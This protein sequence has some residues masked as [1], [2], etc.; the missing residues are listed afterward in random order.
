ML[1]YILSRKPY[2]SPEISNVFQEISGNSD[3]ASLF[4]IGSAVEFAY[5]KDVDWLFFGKG[6]LQDRAFFP[7]RL[8]TLPASQEQIHDYTARSNLD[9][10]TLSPP[11]SCY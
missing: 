3:L 6:I 10:Q 2:T 4:W 7:S 5:H 1:S 9:P 8:E 11:G